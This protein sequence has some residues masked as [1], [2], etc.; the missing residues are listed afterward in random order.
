MLQPNSRAL[1]VVIG[2]VLCL[3]RVLGTNYSKQTDLRLCPHFLEHF[4]ERIIEK[5]LPSLENVTCRRA[6]LSTLSS[7]GYD[8]N[9]I[10]GTRSLRQDANVAVI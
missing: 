9:Q 3:V 10:T 8:A 2:Q 4:F 5:L 7:N 6:H 1:V